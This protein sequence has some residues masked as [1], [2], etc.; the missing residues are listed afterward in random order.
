MKK[1][2]LFLLTF[3][4]F[5][6]LINVFAQE[7][8]DGNGGP[9]RGT[10]N[11]IYPSGVGAI[12]CKNGVSTPPV[13]QR[14]SFLITADGDGLIPDGTVLNRMIYFQIDGATWET[15][16]ENDSRFMEVMLGNFYIDLPMYGTV[17]DS[18]FVA[19]SFTYGGTTFYSDTIRYYLLG[20]PPIVLI[21]SSINGMICEMG[22]ITIGAL[23][24]WESIQGYLGHYNF[25]PKLWYKWMYQGDSVSGGEYVLGSTVT[26]TFNDLELGSNEIEFELFVRDF[27]NTP[28]PTCNVSE[29]INFTVYTPTTPYIEGGGEYC[30]GTET[31]VQIGVYFQNPGLDTVQLK[32]ELF[33][34]DEVIKTMF[35]PFFS[36]N[37]FA[38]D[39]TNTFTLPA[40]TY[41]F[42]TKLTVIN[43][44]GIPSNCIA[45]SESVT[46]EIYE[47]PSVAN[48]GPDQSQCNNG[49]FQLAA[50]EPEV[51]TGVWVVISPYAGLNFDP[52][53]NAHDA[54]LTGVQ[55]G[56]TISLVWRITNGNCPPS[57]D[58]VE[59]TNRLNPTI[60]LED[61]FA[62]VEEDASGTVVYSVSPGDPEDYTF[63]WTKIGSFSGEV[64]ETDPTTYI[65][66]KDVS[67]A[68]RLAVKI[69]DEF[70]CVGIDTM[71]VLVRLTPVITII[72]TVSVCQYG[73]LDI[74]A[75]VVPAANYLFTWTKSADI[76]GTGDGNTF[77]VNTSSPTTHAWV[78]VHVVELVNDQQSPCFAEETVIVTIFEKPIVVIEIGNACAGEELIIE[79]FL[80]NVPAPIITQYIWTPENIQG[81]QPEDEPS[82]YIVNTNVTQTVSGSL[83]LIVV[84]ENGCRDTVSDDIT[85]YVQPVVTIPDTL[86]VCQF[87]ELVITAVVVPDGDYNFAWSGFAGSADEDTY[88]VNTSNPVTN[89]WVAVSVAAP[90]GEQLLSRCI[91]TDTTVIVIF[92]KPIVVIEVD[93][94]CAGADLT[95]E[96]FLQNTTTT[97]NITNYIWTPENIQGEQPTD[98]P[99]TYIV[100]TNVT[101]TVSGS[102]QLIIVDENGCRDTAN[103]DIT[104]FAQPE[105]TIPDTL[106]GCPNTEMVITA[107]ID[108]TGDFQF[109]WRTG[110][111]VGPGPTISGT[112]KEN[113]FRVNTSSIRGATGWVIVEVAEILED[114]TL[115]ECVAT[116]TT[117]IIIFEKPV[118]SFRGSNE[119]CAGDDLTISAVIQ[120]P[121][122]YTITQYIWTPTEIQ[123]EQPTD[124]PNTYIVNTN[125]TQTVSGS[126]QVIVVDENGCRDTANRN[127][128]IY[129]TPVVAIEDDIICLHTD[130]EVVPTVTGGSG[131]NMFEWERLEGGD[132]VP[133]GNDTVLPINTSVAGIQTITVKVTNMINQLSCPSNT[134]T[135]YITV[136]PGVT[137]AYT[138]IQS[139]VVRCE[140]DGE[141]EFQMIATL[142]NYVAGETGR[143]TLISGNADIADLTDP[144]TTII[145]QAR[146][147]AVVSWTISSALG[148]ECGTSS[149]T[150]EM[151]VLPLPV[152]EL[153]NDTA[154][155]MKDLLVIQASKAPNGAFN[156][157]CTWDDSGLSLVPPGYYS[158]C[159]YVVN[160]N[161]PFTG[162]LSVT[163]DA[164]VDS[165]LTF[166]G[167]WLYHKCT[168]LPATINIQVYDSIFAFLELPVVCANADSIPLTGGS[169]TDKNG[170][171]LTGGTFRYSFS[172]SYVTPGC[173]LVAP[174]SPPR[175]PINSASDP[176]EQRGDVFYYYP[177]LNPYG[178]YIIYEYTDENGCKVCTG[179]W[180]ENATPPEILDLDNIVACAYDIDYTITIDINDGTP[181]FEIDWIGVD[182]LN[183]EQIDSLN[184]KFNFANVSISDA[185]TITI[186]VTDSNSCVGEMEFDVII[187]PLPAL[188]VP[189]DISVCENGPDFDIVVGPET[190]QDIEYS[191]RT[192]LPNGVTMIANITTN[193]F[194]PFRPSLYAA[195]YG[196]GLYIIEVKAVD[197]I[198]NCVSIDTVKVTLFEGP[199]LTPLNDT[200]VCLNDD[201]EMI[202]WALYTSIDE[203]G[204][205]PYQHGFRFI[206]DPQAGGLGG[207]EN[208]NEA[209]ANRFSVIVDT[210]FTGAALLEI[211]I[212]DINGCVDTAR[213]FV[214]VAVPPS[215]SIP[216]VE[217]CFHPELPGIEVTA[218]GTGT[219]TPFD[220]VWSTP[221]DT[222][223]TFEYVGP[224]TPTTETVEITYSEPITTTYTVVVTDTNKCSASATADLIILPLPDVS[225]D[226]RANAPPV[227]LESYQP[228]WTHNDTTPYICVGTPQFILKGGLPVGGTYKGPGVGAPTLIGQF[229]NPDGLEPNVL[230][231]IWY[232]YEDRV[233]GC[234][235][236]ISDDLIIRRL[237]IA[238]LT[239]PPDTFC[240]NT[241]SP[242]APSLNP[243]LFGNL[244]D[245]VFT[246]S[247]AGQGI[248]I[249]EN[250]GVLT[251]N[252]PTPGDY[253]ITWHFTDIYCQNDT[254]VTIHV[255]ERPTVTLEPNP[256]RI[257][258]IIGTQGP[259]AIV[260][261]A[262]IPNGTAPFT[263][264]WNDFHGNLTPTFQL[265][266]YVGTP[267][268][269]FNIYRWQFGEDTVRVRVTDAYG[270]ESLVEWAPVTID[271]LP[272]LGIEP[273]QV[274]A[275]IDSILLEHGYF[276]DS[277]G[278]KQYNRGDF[279]YSSVPSGLD[280]VAQDVDG[281]WWFYPQRALIALP[282]PALPA[283][284]GVQFIYTNEANCTDS[285]AGQITVVD[286]PRVSID[287]RYDFCVADAIA[288][289]EADIWGGTVPYRP[290]TWDT[291]LVPRGT[292]DSATYRL[293]VTTDIV[294]KVWVYVVDDNGCV[295]NTDTAVVEIHP[296][297][298]LAEV[299]VSKACCGETG[300][301]EVELL[302]GDRDETIIDWYIVDETTG[303]LVS[304][305]TNVTSISFIGLCLGDPDVNYVVIATDE[306]YFCAD[307][308]YYTLK[309]QP[310]PVANIEVD[311]A[312]NICDN[313]EITLNATVTLQPWAV[314]TT[315]QHYTW[316]VN[317]YSDPVP[318]SSV[319]PCDPSLI[320][321]TEPIPALNDLLSGSYKV[322]LASGETRM[323]FVLLVTTEDYN[324]PISETSCCIQVEPALKITGGGNDTICHGGSVEILYTISDFQPTQLGGVRTFYRWRE[325]NLYHS[326]ISEI[327]MLPLGTNQIKFTTT[328]GLHTNENG[329]ESYCYTVEVWQ[330]TPSSDDPNCHCW[331]FD[332]VCHI[333]SE[334]HWVTVIKDGTLTLSGPVYVQKDANEPPVFIANV[335]DGYGDITY[336]WYLN[337]V[338]V[339]GFT[340][341][342]YTMNDPDVLGTIGTYHIAVRAKQNTSGCETEVKE[343]IF[344]VIHGCGLVT[345]V[346]PTEGCVG[347]IITL[348]A[349][350]EVHENIDYTLQWKQG[351]LT[352]M[353]YIIGETGQTYTFIVPNNIDKIEYQ[354]DLT[355][356]GCEIVNAASS[357]YFQ[358]LPTTV[359]WVDDY[360][361]CENG[362]VEVEVNVAN[363]DG[364]IYRY[365]WHDDKTADPFDITYVNHRLFK[366]EEIIGDATTFY[367]KVQM[368]NAICSSEFAEFVISVQGALDS[369][370]LIAD[371]TAIC[372]GE[373]VHFTLGEDPNIEE[374]G[375]PT[376]SWW[377]NGIEL[378]G[379]SLEDLKIPFFTMGQ[380]YAQ[381]FVEVRL[382]YPENMCEF[383]TNR[384][385][386]DVYE[387]P[388]VTIVGPSLVCDTEN[389]TVLRAYL[390]PITI[391]DNLVS[392]QWFENEVP[393]G[394]QWEQVVS[395]IPSPYAY[396]Y[397]VEVTYG[398]ANCK[399]QAGPFEVL[400]EKFANVGITASKTRVCE[401]D[402]M[403]KLE[404]EL[405]GMVTGNMTYEWLADDGDTV[406]PVG[407][408]APII[409]VTPEKT[410]TYSLVITQEESECKANSNAIKV[411]VFERPVIEWVTISDTAICEGGAVVLTANAIDGAT[412]TWYQNGLPIAN[413]AQHQIVVF[414]ITSG[415]NTKTYIYTVT[416]SLDMGCT[417]CTCTSDISDAVS[418]IV[419]PQPNV[420]IEGPTEIC[421]G[422][423]VTLTGFVTNY[424]PPATDDLTFLWTL[425][426]ADGGPVLAEPYLEGFE[427][428]FETTLGLMLTNQDGFDFSYNIVPA[429]NT[430]LDNSLLP[431]HNGGFLGL[432]PCAT[433]LGTGYQD[434][435][436]MGVEQANTPGETAGL[437]EAASRAGIF[438]AGKLAEII[439]L[440]TIA[441][442]ADAAMAGPGISIAEGI[443]Q[444]IVQA[445]AIL[446]DMFVNAAID[447][448]FFNNTFLNT[449]MTNTNAPNPDPADFE[450]ACAIPWGTLQNTNYR[451][452]Y[453]WGYKKAYVTAYQDAYKTIV[454]DAIIAA[455]V[456]TYADVFA[457]IFDMKGF[458]TDTW[459]H[460]IWPVGELPA[461][462][463]PYN[464][465]LTVSNANGCIATEEHQVLVNPEPQVTI[466]STQTTICVDGTVLLYAH[467]VEQY[468]VFE[469]TFQ[470]F[471]NGVAIEGENASD[472]IYTGTDPATDEISFTVTKNNGCVAKSNI[473]VVTV[474]PKPVVEWIEVSD[475]DICEGGSVVLTAN[476]I[477][478]ATYTWFK[479]GSIL[480]GAILYQIIDFPETE[481]ENTRTH[482]YAAIASLFLDCE[483]C[484]CISEISD[485]VTVTVVPQPNVVIEGP[486]EIC[487]GMPVTLTG[488]VTN[489]NPPATDD[490]IFT[491]TMLDATGGPAL[492]DDYL[493]GFEGA[494]ETTLGLL[495]TNQ[496]GFNFSYNIN[497]A[498][499]TTLENAL[500]PSHNGGFL[501]LVPCATSLGT[502][503]Q[504]MY[505]MGVEQAAAAG[506]TAGLAEAAS[507]AGAFLAGK[508]DEI[509][510]IATLAATADAA[511]AGPG[512]S[513]ADGIL[514]GNVQA[515]AILTDMFVNT[516]ID[517]SFFNNNFLNTRMTNS[518]APNPDTDD[519]VAACAIPWGTLQS[520]YYRDG[521][522]YGYKKAFV[523]AHQ[524]AYKE[525]VSA[526]IIAAYVDVYADVFATEFDL[527][528]YTTNTF[529]GPV[530]IIEDLPARPNPYNFFLTVANE[531]GCITTEQH[532]VLVN[533]AP[534][535]TIHASETTICVDGTVLF[536]AHDLEQYS[537]FETTFQW[538]LNGVAIEGENATDYIYTGTIATIDE[539]SFTATKNNGCVAQSNVIQITVIEKP[540]I[541]YEYLDVTI[542]QEEQVQFHVYLKQPYPYPATFTWRINTVV[543]EGDGSTWNSLVYNFNEPGV[544]YVDVQATSPMS[545]CQTGIIW[546]ATVIVKAPPTVYIEGA[547]LVCNTEEP[548]KLLAIVEPTN[549]T[550]D[551]KWTVTH[552]GVTQDLG[553]EQTQ[554]VSNVPS[555]YP[556]IY[557]VEITDYESGCVVLAEAHTV[558]VGQFATIAIDADRK[559]VCDGEE[560]ILTAD[561]D[562]TQ[563]IEYQ[564]YADGV[565]ITDETGPVL[566]IVPPV[567][568]TTYTFTAIQVESNCIANSNA[569]IVTVVPIPVIEE[570]T[571]S[572]THICEGGAVIVTALEEIPGATYTWYENGIQLTNAALYQIVVFP[573][574]KGENE[575]TYV[576]TATATVDPGCVSETVAS[577]MITVVPQPNVVIEGPTD[578]CESAEITLTGFV[579]NYSEPA[580][581]DL[582]FRWML[583]DD[584]GQEITPDEYLT[585]FG[586]SVDE[587]VTLML[588][589][590]FNA[591]NFNYQIVPGNREGWYSA[592]TLGAAPICFPIT[593]NSLRSMYQLG[594]GDA[595][596][597]GAAVIDGQDA[598]INKAETFFETDLRANVEGIATASALADVEMAG[599]TLTA[600]AG[601]LQGSIQAQLLS[602]VIVNEVITGSIFNLNVLPDDISSLLPIS[603]YVQ[604]CFLSHDA[605]LDAYRDGYAFS[606]KG[607]YLEAYQEAYINTIMEIII[608]AYVNKYVEVFTNGY[609][610]LGY[611]TN[612]WE[613]EQSITVKLPARQYAYNFFLTV[614]NDNGCIATEQHQVFVHPSPII[615]TTIT[616]NPDPENGRICDGGQLQLTAVVEDPAL[617]AYYVWY[618]NGFIIEGENL[619]TVWVSPTTVDNDPTLYTYNVIAM[620][621]EYEP[622][623]PPQ[624]VDEIARTILV[625]RNPIV[626]ITGQ[627]HVCD[628]YP[629]GAPFDAI[630]N[631]ILTAKVNGS[632]EGG[633]CCCEEDDCYGFINCDWQNYHWY[634]N[635]SRV[636]LE[637]YCD[638]Q[639]LSMYLP[640]SSEAHLFK[641]EYVGG[642]GCNAWSQEFDVYVHPQQII[643]V[644]PEPTEDVV[645]I[646]EGGS[647]ILRA[648]HNN[649]IETDYTYQWYRGAYDEANL[650]PGATE[651]LYN[652]GIINEIGDILYIVEVKQVSTF[653]DNQ[654]IKC[655]V[656][657]EYILTVIPKPTI[658]E[659]TISEEYIC[660]G[661][662]VTLT[663]TPG[664]DNVGITPVYTWT[665]N[666]IILQGITGPTFTKSLEAPNGDGTTYTYNVTVKYENSGCESVVNPALAQTVT[667]YQKPI[668]HISGHEN[669]C[670]TD[671]IVLVA[672]V[673]GLSA[674]VGLLQYI[675]SVDGEDRP[676]EWI[677]DHFSQF[678]AEPWAPRENPYHIKVTV[679]RG[680]GCTAESDEHLVTVHVK[681]I[682]TITSTE[683]PVCEGGA[684][685]LTANLADYNQTHMTYQ[686]YTHIE[687]TYTITLGDEV[688]EYTEIVVTP[689]PG[690]TQR[691]YETGALTETATFGV[692]VFQ[693][694][695]R[696]ISEDVYTVVVTPIP[697][698][699]AEEVE[700]TICNGVQVS[701]SVS[702]ELEGEPVIA[703]YKWFVNGIELMG[704]TGDSYTMTAT[705]AGTYIYEVEAT[706]DIAGC[707]SV[708]TL[709]G[710][711]T[712]ENPVTVV[713]AGNGFIC[714]NAAGALLTAMINPEDAVVNYE[715]F[716]FGEPIEGATNSTLDISDYPATYAQ[717]AFTVKVT[718]PVSECWDLS[719][720]HYVQI[721]TFANVGIEVNPESVCEGERVTLIANTQPEINKI[722][723]WY[724][725][726]INGEEVIGDAP[727]AYHY[728]VLTT[729]YRFTITENGSGCG[730][731]S[732]PATVVVIP[733]P[734]I[735][736]LVGKDSTICAGEQLPFEVQ[737]NE[738]A[739]FTWYKNDVEIP[740]AGNASLFNYTFNEPGV[741][742]IEVSAT[743]VI[744][745]CP[746]E[747]V[748]VATITVK[749]A[750]S[751]SIEGLT[752]VCA[753]PETPHLL[754][755]NVE[756]MGANVTYQWY[757]DGNAVENN[758]S[759]Y[760]EIE[761]AQRDNP[762]I[763]VVIITDQVSGCEVQSDPH[764]VYVNTDPIITTTAS[765]YDICKDELVTFTAHITPAVNMT[766]Q[767]YADGHEITAPNANQTIYTEYVERTTIYTFSATHTSGCTATSLPLKINVS[768]E[769][770]W[771][772]TATEHDICQYQQ[773]PGGF[774]IDPA[775]IN[776]GI[777]E[778]TFQWSINGVEVPGAI[779]HFFNPVFDQAGEFKV[780]VV[781]TTIL[782]ECPSEVVLFATV[783]V[784]AAVEV[785][786]AGI[787]EMCGNAANATL[788]AYTNPL[789]ANVEYQWYLNNHPILGET[790]STL[791]ISDLTVG[792]YSY[793]VE[794]TA[795]PSGCVRSSDV[796]YVNVIE[797]LTVSAN[798]NPMAICAGEPV[799]LTAT[800]EEQLQNMKYQWYANGTAIPEPYGTSLEAQ[801]YPMVTTEYYLVAKQEGTQCATKSNTVTVIVTQ[802][803]E[804]P[805]L[806]ISDDMICSG[807]QVTITVVG[808]PDAGY[809]WFK[810]GPQVP[811]AVNVGRTITDNPTATNG[812]ETHSYTAVLTVN[813]CVS[814]ESDPVTV[815]V[816]P[817]LTV[818]LYG[819]HEICYQA[820]EELVLHAEIT[821]PALPGVNYL[822]DLT[823]RQG[824]NPE[825]TTVG[826]YQTPYMQIP[827]WLEPNDPVNPYYFF[828]KVRAEHYECTHKSEG[829]LV[830]ILPQDEVQIAVNNNDI[831]MGGTITAYADVTSAVAGNYNYYWTINGTPVPASNNE[832]IVITN[833]LL[834]FGPNTIAVE[835]KRIGA[836]ESCGGTHSKIVR[837]FAAPE[838]S[839]SQNYEGMCVGGQVALEAEVVYFEG[840]V[841]DIPTTYT[842]YLGG[843]E[844]GSGP[845]N[846]ITHVPGVT[847]DD[848]LHQYSVIVK[849]ANETLGCEVTANFN[850]IKVV[851]QATVSIA[852]AGAQYDVC[853]EATVQIDPLPV[854]S[855][856]TIQQISGWCWAWNSDNNYDCGSGG[857]SSLVVPGFPTVGTHTYSLAINFAH[858]TCNTATSNDVK[859]N[860][861]ASPEWGTINV[862]L[863]DRCLGEKVTLE[864]KL[865]DISTNPTNVGTLQ[866]EYSMDNGA[867]WI[868]QPEIQ[869]GGGPRD[870]YPKFAGNYLY[871][872]NYS[873]IIPATGC[874]LDPAQVGPIAIL[875]LPTAA[876]VEEGTIV[877]AC[878]NTEVTLAIDID[879]NQ[880]SLFPYIDLYIDNNVPPMVR[881]TPSM[882]ENGVYYHKVRPTVT[883]QYTITGAVTHNQY[884]CNSSG[885]LNSFITVEVTGIA[886]LTTSPIKTCEQSVEVEFKITSL[887]GYEK[888]TVIFKELGITQEYPIKPV[889]NH[890]IITVEI[891]EGT[892]GINNVEIFVGNND[893]DFECSFAIVII[894]GAPGD[895]TF[896]TEKSDTQLCVGHMSSNIELVVD[897]KGTAPFLYR[898]TG[899]DGTF[900]DNQRSEEYQAVISLP[901]PVQTTIYTI[902]LYGDDGTCVGEGTN[903][904]IM[905]IVTDVEVLYTAVNC[906][907][908]NMVIELQVNSLLA[909][910]A[911][912]RLENE[913]T[914]RWTNVPI[915]NNT[916]SLNMAGLNYD[917]YNLILTI[918]GCEFLA[919]VIYLDNRNG[920]SLIHRRWE[921]NS[922][923]LVVSNYY[924]CD[925]EGYFNGG[926][927]FT[928]YQWYKNGQEIPGATQG[929]YQ[930]P[931][932]LNGEYTVHLTGYKVDCDGVRGHRVDFTTCDQAFS[933]VSSVKVYPVPARIDEPVNVDL[934]MTIEELEGATLDIYDARGAHI[935]HIKVTS[936][937]TQV[938]GFK[939]Q[940]TYFGK[941]TTGTNEIKAVKFVIV[942]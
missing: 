372:S 69:T 892:V 350:V 705:T 734:A 274:C 224:K 524:E 341:S 605:Q 688:I 393:K 13:T 354:I 192:T 309:Y 479:N 934:D 541:E 153:P 820:L 569:I 706:V 781:A 540:V 626:E 850:P 580:T 364:Q 310:N 839:I 497:P 653:D 710:T 794:V 867:S 189:E 619:S 806:T 916:I 618:Q 862:L 360:I 657:A 918:D 96:S 197:T 219:A 397:V 276:I 439:D 332:T 226:I 321:R 378:P 194:T 675:W 8:P 583:L 517:A 124:V 191:F 832:T 242:V 282:P 752:V 211:F 511:M 776:Y 773:V 828:V 345:I 271:S 19:A 906:A 725:A 94:V 186:I 625:I 165:T 431:S 386:I 620:P 544:Y 361:I 198:T 693:T 299:V 444:G 755:A 437:A 609:S 684:V 278:V 921:N 118:V 588:D 179:E 807:D 363:W 676:N 109:T 929:F 805:V 854:I 669:F 574:T 848:Q 728:P 392:Y 342:H 447:A 789:I 6:G 127:I 87:E 907:G 761:M 223:I 111:I 20:A 144:S 305:G 258:Q 533:P 716:L 344:H 795:I 527:L 782:T 682:V 699:I 71:N 308:V 374:F 93:D 484:A 639:K 678:Y 587:I 128:T 495:L 52:S 677:D 785:E 480:P 460:A 384:V 76:D 793:K 608:N 450:A 562:G 216:D 396:N 40:G 156:Y 851:P 658:A 387:A 762:Y 521:Y 713:I 530:W 700:E 686:W 21:P 133:A 296:L 39:S 672:Y 275:N 849:S 738:D 34:N 546:V 231:T 627:H 500:L 599:R 391:D 796:H 376:I 941:I 289:I 26:N 427:G 414:P 339:E 307:T 543:V 760:Q 836:G 324:C 368:L 771:D 924:K 163:I 885:L 522:A 181:P 130:Y 73:E 285:V 359:A 357:H 740:G 736:V 170:N 239:Y 449:R 358:V 331:E 214:T 661:A 824:N 277:D 337:G 642:L 766:Y 714:E 724:A 208:Y 695:S 723:T 757:L 707:V 654:V 844:I 173:T 220:F 458:T 926:Y 821:P 377:V 555:P 98:E 818:A 134:D 879:V 899:T 566:Q 529:T 919:P 246:I 67:G 778:V 340:G 440:A 909:T 857:V 665:E 531:N 297:P 421:E 815:Q 85:I 632:Y 116:D 751:V 322:D 158:G 23:S 603:S 43:K 758:N 570:V 95:V 149:D 143:W 473:I 596:L 445:Q 775:T 855:D 61:F 823:Y 532:Q 889:A 542:C 88:T 871:K 841:T 425:L 355:C 457:G 141:F 578:I 874:T 126:L 249:N 463:N 719:P 645:P 394:Q 140:E 600:L 898:L 338:K 526:A 469:A 539:I 667:V 591:H 406:I 606:Y 430:T 293:D 54:I 15:V 51:G 288:S 538:Y 727:N 581:D 35:S 176:V 922:D 235:D 912:V 651:P 601:N 931:L 417:I 260:E 733:A 454:S 876:F 411:T 756:P 467:D 301:L 804:P 131:N 27:Y 390:D 623:C 151:I 404:A 422:M 68:G 462:P 416:A 451:D 663:A 388:S 370:E 209:L 150:L 424:N 554:V 264:D 402:N 470:W 320:T 634:W 523:T 720:I 819:T 673:D 48:A 161:Q 443:A 636:Y 685:V 468:S 763:Y 159:T 742:R 188:E 933:S 327:Y 222:V 635:G 708:R 869:V 698:V 418:V 868:G 648:H 401:D 102:L 702:T 60:T 799:Q 770:N 837:V 135:A 917:A 92:E 108:L 547:S 145:V 294:G 551:Y 671:P 744:A 168:S 585:A 579:T 362:A 334:C 103:G 556:Y 326:D 679:T 565:V 18:L 607:I 248:T 853:I 712:V 346:G 703:T 487:E 59:V 512:I 518:S 148:G 814:N 166:A 811:F 873:P 423:P 506:E 178:G 932:G 53:N 577:P 290:I 245:Y 3:L 123:G 234:I 409:Y 78:N 812:F 367:V 499:N 204:Y 829:H 243:I 259:D 284:F 649:Y 858:P 777:D 408:N 835:I 809:T 82:T 697:V 536:E 474:M 273:D 436:D 12:Y 505:N 652:T 193:N 549:A 513:I 323:Q 687:E 382:V 498:L 5:V 352:S 674:N 800:M 233:T 683:N 779:F 718:D 205:L 420:V 403:V 612:V 486:T 894:V 90:L 306:T 75:S 77:T 333:F 750:P 662:Q 870:H 453:A 254:F 640:A 183:G 846:H 225:F 84:D 31:M 206:P 262:A 666:G 41:E 831:C 843:N 722:Y 187:S 113:I 381:Y 910:V 519:Y 115:S 24:D 737:A 493:E 803:P 692:K 57:L 704:V 241:A 729:T 162:T 590:E 428:A 319:L 647:V 105:V 169:Q 861:V 515:R 174:Y 281:D 614:S 221:A 106:K 681:P 17:V 798:V 514:Q 459:P 528:D 11:S 711:I 107:G 70:N 860:V 265:P 267:D 229:F 172:F 557:L 304:A 852:R 199:R 419:V 754:Y 765:K 827:N 240:V 690:A 842:W 100:N 97:P 263:Y 312:C 200:I 564:W 802:K 783:N 14:V 731:T 516:T 589:N 64:D 780:R 629:D 930:D 915:V 316:S 182:A 595:V 747:I 213:A 604:A 717:Y 553:T 122:P 572:N 582:N 441:A 884:Q 399:A 534:L 112:A 568:Q 743:S 81:E 478:G 114:G 893:D 504:D 250:T 735:T 429:L 446:T 548:T 928:S 210:R 30:E 353:E 520:S 753:E 164:V 660:A 369:V 767:W 925:G 38:F 351:D 426:D 866:W 905:V 136:L 329:P 826:S 16:D 691:T 576:Y 786:I 939:A 395:N 442:E 42:Y 732:N 490:L 496:P 477:E 139:P 91:A 644:L 371:R 461:R 28:V 897:F 875:P 935:Q 380:L 253:T 383:V 772:I 415:E 201:L 914:I 379:E 292:G 774:V 110:P 433:S 602:E 938:D 492:S 901:A 788:Y 215:V 558:M 908:D 317:F 631:V 622:N 668:V 217:V 152:V 881:V 257:C 567:G 611:F 119:V 726:T 33:Q 291:N 872:I 400:V 207:W 46:V 44:S 784:G 72:D 456:E 302:A 840:L 55:P 120:R 66:Y 680:N 797:F 594:M 559:K 347:D 455:Y 10:P 650:I 903:D 882:V 880:F 913:N 689:I 545:A 491:W 902:T 398:P 833:D 203:P 494:F 22:S 146:D 438:L 452:G 244:I 154:V 138:N 886:V 389:P 300:T 643:T 185:I 465:F 502:G 936:R 659:V 641:M 816:H 413:A 313:S 483:R 825:E 638:A 2:T 615:P 230:Y 236:S 694:I 270:C 808:G 571:V 255:R 792:Y 190:I 117:F 1:I 314:G 343:H 791:D 335:I 508:L 628:I 7:K 99:S 485:A 560:V 472:Y 927:E 410:T 621:Y 272:R 466:H 349:I 268:S 328:P 715:W 47:L 129:Q 646:C 887:F 670:E 137:R 256:I 336:T 877:K 247:P 509:I 741:W 448:S 764:T 838:L 550:V 552:N 348:A 180:M 890:S 412:Y 266:H 212:S 745:G 184:Y 476:K 464:F 790:G 89:G 501:G 537:V 167:Q 859:F 748:L 834:V 730:A 709:V 847:T 810:N 29:T 845:L 739:I 238:S 252:N 147:T 365:L 435:Y 573:I 74:I 251:F 318:G 171:A 330:G 507:R 598:A 62:C 664:E 295:S 49:T 510:G 655:L 865:L 286:Y 160:T 563:N 822:Y 63:E 911:Q 801:H 356:G 227:R 471:L 86:R 432:V 228:D 4:L 407:E 942:K 261:V 142:P 65:I 405:Y 196:Y 79:S 373:M 856:P 195:T 696:C 218:T 287:D 481:G 813:G 475:P 561:V 121:Y 101:Q 891:P 616:M 157:D 617:V 56:T 80:Q 232:I 503:Y 385:F 592:T 237:P 701:M 923:V 637:D 937:I 489:Y 488:F 610:E 586:E 769:I 900:L 768:S 830:N 878:A 132:F 575:W 749:E 817:T 920:N 177:N 864:A 175:N 896:D 298:K 280:Y 721:G 83:Q 375:V 624:I 895:A 279:S 888:A 36:T 746:S 125:V 325:N 434:M 283:Y 58:T 883:T 155:C 656:T 32:F 104:I 303:D 311:V 597:A 787:T 525:I 45:E 940:G 584:N 269:I 202:T 366:Y 633:H 50:T 535:V 904:Q 482:E 25:D 593:A 759:P 613:G 9:S 863:N 630:P 315:V 37:S